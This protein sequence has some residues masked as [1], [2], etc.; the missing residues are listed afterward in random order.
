MQKDISVRK[1]ENHTEWEEKGKDEE[2]VEMSKDR[3]ECD[4]GEGRH[5]ETLLYEGQEAEIREIRKRECGK[6]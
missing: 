1:I 4:R 2:R 5:E 3:R 6:L